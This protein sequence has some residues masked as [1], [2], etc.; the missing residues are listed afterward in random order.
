MLQILDRL[1]EIGIY[2]KIYEIVVQKF[3]FVLYGNN[4][5]RSLG[6]IKGLDFPFG[7]F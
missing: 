7:I 5:L 4:F 2:I 3:Y 1:D 6:K